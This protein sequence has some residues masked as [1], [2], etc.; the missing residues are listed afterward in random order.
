MNIFIKTIP[1]EEIKL[2]HGFTACDWWWEV[3][4][5]Q[6]VVATEITNWREAM[7]LAIHEAT[8]ALMCKHLG[9]THQ[10][11]DLFDAQYQARHESDLNAGDEPDAPYRVPH[12]YA[13]AIERILTGVLEVDWKTYDFNLDK[14]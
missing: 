3:E 1:N 7:S 2:R 6:V 9:I 14:L 10:Q 11:V 8:E 12:N 4:D 5:L 13:T